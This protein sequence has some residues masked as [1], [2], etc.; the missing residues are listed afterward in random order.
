MNETDFLSLTSPIRLAN[1]PTMKLGAAAAETVP[2]VSP[3]P[4][5]G[6][7]C[8]VRVPTFTSASQAHKLTVTELDDI[9]VV[10]A[11]DDNKKK[12]EDSPNDGDDTNNNN[13]RALVVRKKPAQLPPFVISHR[14]RPPSPI[15]SSSNGAYCNGDNDNNNFFSDANTSN[16]VM[17]SQLPLSLECD[18][19]VR[20]TELYK[21]IQ[22]KN[23]DQVMELLETDKA[24][25]ASVWVVRK[26]PSGQLRCVVHVVRPVT[27]RLVAGRGG[28]GRGLCFVPLRFTYLSFALPVPCSLGWFTFYSGGGCSPSTRASSSAPRT[29]SSKPCSACTRRRR[30]PR[31]IRGC[32]PCT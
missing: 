16:E 26:E 10:A 1:R 29:A 32:C 23:W 3:T 8:G 13:S 17:N 31:T 20:P 30:P 11:V 27:G 28:A 18:Y 9:R 12:K 25:E 5:T 22:A 21:H 14:E 6:C 7:G 19:D 15:Y 2:S 4:E 24:I